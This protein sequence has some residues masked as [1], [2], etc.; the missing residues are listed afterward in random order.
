MIWNVVTFWLGSFVN[1]SVVTFWLDS[2]VNWSVVTFW[3]DSFVIWSVITFWSKYDSNT[4]STRL[5]DLD[6]MVMD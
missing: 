1:W 3:L 5:S 4:T 2:F 6:V